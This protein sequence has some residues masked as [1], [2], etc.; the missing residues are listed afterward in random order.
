MPSLAIIDPTS[1]FR[2]SLAALVS[3]LGF[4]PVQEATDLPDLMQGIGDLPPPDV[5]SISLRHAPADIGPFMDEVRGWAPQTRVVF[6]AARFDEAALV[7]GFAAG[8]AGY[9]TET[10]SREGLKRSLQL[11]SAGEKVFPSELAAALCT[12]RLQLCG[13]ADAGRRLQDLRATAR[14][15]EVLRCLAN[16]DSNHA[17][18]A[19]LGI[20][21][22]AVGADVRHILRKLGVSNRTQAALWAVATGLAAP[23]AGPEIAVR[24]GGIA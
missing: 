14:E 18:A 17:I 1:L 4:D 23:L 12:A 9:V 5:M 22:P 21:E 11:V 15:I 24:P 3:T 13:P 20:S 8:A 2:T 10:I 6:I 19:K 16:G 7:A